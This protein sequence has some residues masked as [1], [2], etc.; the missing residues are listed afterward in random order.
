MFGRFDFRARAFVCRTLVTISLLMPLSA[1]Q[2]QDAT[3]ACIDAAQVLVNASSGIR[4]A[5]D[6]ARAAAGE[7]TLNWSSSTGHQ[8]SCR[9]DSEGRLFAVTVSRFPA[10]G[11]DVDDSYSLTCESVG[12]RRR[13]CRLR[14][15]PSLAT[16]ERQLS[17]TACVQG[18]TFGVSGSVLW[19]DRGCR[20]RFRITPLWESYTL[21]CNSEGMRR[22]ECR[23]RS[24]SIVRLVRTTSRSR[25][26]EGHS[27]GHSGSTLW[28][29]RGC[30]GVFEVSPMFEAGEQVEMTKARNACERHVSSQGFTV[31]D[32]LDARSTGRYIELTLALRRGQIAT[33]TI[34]SYDTRTGR[35]ETRVRR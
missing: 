25:C 6:T 35:T 2:A 34:C 11:A 20:G 27:W 28:V 14:S 23:T 22:Q 26:I 8:G 24:S 29:D 15:A 4:T 3:R 12:N 19:V 32:E 10:D 17:N 30:A 18:S 9:F 1:V 21:S 31:S 16:L 33:T 7:R 5:G 13:E